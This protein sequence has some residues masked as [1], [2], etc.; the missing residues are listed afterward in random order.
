MFYDVSHNIAAFSCSCCDATLFASK[1]IAYLVK[2]HRKRCSIVGEVDLE[3]ISFLIY[4]EF[5][6]DG[7]VFSL[8]V[9]ESMFD[10]VTEY[11]VTESLQVILCH[12]DVDAFCVVWN[13]LETLL[14]VFVPIHVDGEERIRDDKAIIGKS[15]IIFF[16][17][18]VIVMSIRV[19]FQQELINID[20]LWFSKLIFSRENFEYGGERIDSCLLVGYLFF[21]SLHEV[22]IAHR[23][24]MVDVI[25]QVLS[26]A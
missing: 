13:F 9:G 20:D 6:P 26:C 12:E 16:Y 15:L 21:H 25:F 11:V 23:V 14:T 1:S 2:A 19:V 7:I 3:H 10:G 18:R 8:W 24:L 22:F 4:G 5:N 17:L